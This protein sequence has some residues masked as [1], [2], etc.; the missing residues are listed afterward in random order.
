MTESAFLFLRAVAALALGLLAAVAQAQVRA[1]P[2]VPRP[3]DYIVAVVNQE[4]VTAGELQQRITR[5]R[6]DAARTKTPLPAV[7]E[8]RRQILD[9]LIDERVQV[10]YARESGQ[11]LDEAELDRAV[12]NVA[13][14]NQLTPAQLR[15]RLRKDG[16]DFSRFRNN[17]RD[18]LLTER[19]REREVQA[20]IRITDEEVDAFVEKRRAAAGSL[21]EY[22]IAQLL[23][24]VPDG[25][26]VPAV[27]ERRARAQ[28]ALARIKAGEDFSAVVREISDD[29]NKAQGGV[30]GLA[31]R[32]GWALVGVA[33]FAKL[34][35]H[36][37]HRHD[38]PQRMRVAPAW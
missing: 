38:L 16:L 22:N 17:V 14:Q 15:E 6:E 30:I 12:A 7:D 29:A 34:Y 35:L 33:T 20:R 2:A 5:V 36:P 1:A 13:L 10:T 25:A 31:K 28:A 21:A 37:V 8:L 3:G 27:A 24:S 23:V 32:A 4:L 18:Q 9:L 19:V 26:T 11:R